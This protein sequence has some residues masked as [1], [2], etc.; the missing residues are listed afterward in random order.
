M[1]SRHQSTGAAVV[2]PDGLTP[3]EVYKLLIG[4]VVPRPIAWVSS[5]SADGVANLAPFSFF[6][7]VSCQPPMVSVTFVR[8]GHSDETPDKDTLANIK[9]TGEYAVNVVP[10]GLAQPM[11]R[12]SHPYEPDVD[13]FQRAGLTP[14][15]SDL[16]SAPR[17]GEAPISMECRLETT[18]RP[19]SDTVAIG[20][21]LRFHFHPELLLENGRIDVE[22]LDPLARLA[23]DY[24]SISAPF[25]V[26]LDPE[27]SLTS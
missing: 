13:E 7:V 2:D 16:I 27:E 4:S 20:R 1:P 17:V 12:S 9:A 25:P 21:I 26:P 14:V 11:V 8:R 10:A 18:I 24:A 5:R 3:K 23:G 6:N 22:A 15:E 19:G